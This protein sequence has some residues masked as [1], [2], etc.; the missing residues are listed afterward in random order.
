MARPTLKEVGKLQK[1]L[2]EEKT[3][4]IRIYLTFNKCWTQLNTNKCTFYFIIM[5]TLTASEAQL[6]SLI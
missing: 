6:G 1:T 3:K 2:T 5:P 4:V